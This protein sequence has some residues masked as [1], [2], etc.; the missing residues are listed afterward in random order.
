MGEG[1]DEGQRE[2]L[3][4]LPEWA[5]VRRMPRMEAAGPWPEQAGTRW[6]LRPCA[7]TRGRAS[8][9]C[10]PARRNHVRRLTCLTAN[11]H[12]GNMVRRQGCRLAA[13]NF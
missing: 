12:T 6:A 10:Y 9:I 5:H 13:A 8:D 2:R 4:P 3:L 7:G 1:P 11:G